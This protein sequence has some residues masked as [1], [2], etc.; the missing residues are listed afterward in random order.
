MTDIDD[1]LGNMNPSHVECRDWLHDWK[2]WQAWLIKGGGFEEHRKCAQCGSVCR[3][4]VDKHGYTV[5][6]RIDYA[7]D[8]VIKGHG[9]LTQD[10][11]AAIRLA[12]AKSQSQRKR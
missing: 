7:T 11:R 5:L 4:I 2:P 1:A 12:S 3:R 10:D 6:R 8:Y 9:R